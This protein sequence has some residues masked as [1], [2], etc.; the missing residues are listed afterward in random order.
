MCES[1]LL[2]L[3]ISFATI[4]IHGLCQHAQEGYDEDV[5]W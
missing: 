5:M 1:I 3:D 2:L 4:S